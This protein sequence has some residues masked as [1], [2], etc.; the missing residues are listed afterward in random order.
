MKKD[1]RT[2]GLALPFSILALTATVLRTIACFTD[3]NYGS[4]FFGTATLVHISDAIMVILVFSLIASLFLKVEKKHSEHSFAGPLV[5]LPTGVFA[6]SLLFL[7]MDIIVYVAEK[8]SRFASTSIFSERSFIVAIA[9]AIFALLTIVYLALVAFISAPRSLIRANF[10]MLAALFFALYTAFVYFRAGAPINQPQ[11]ILTEMTML[12]AALF[13]LEETRISLGRER[14]RGYFILGAITAL[15]S[16][17]TALPV[18]LVYVF[19]AKV[20]SSSVAELIF[21]IALL[22]FSISRLLH[23]LNL[24]DGSPSPLAAAIDAHDSP[25]TAEEDV[26]DNFLQIS[27]DDVA[28]E[29]E[30]QIENEEDSSN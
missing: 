20:L 10:G 23:T 29:G 12:A 7:A 4:G 9:A 13:F 24:S 21:L 28:D 6:M 22:A 5:Y 17:Y 8:A 11:R 27:I 1:F 18:L 14:W 15:L 16:L 30:R 19:R 26:E 2:F 25:D 3:M